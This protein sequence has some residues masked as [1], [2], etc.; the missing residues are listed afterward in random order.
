[1]KRHAT[2]KDYAN[3]GGDDDFARDGDSSP[4]RGGGALVRAAGEKNARG[5]V[6]MVIFL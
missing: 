2:A 6:K 3:G 1:M 4:S 5:G